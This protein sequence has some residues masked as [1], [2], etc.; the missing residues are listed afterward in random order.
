M[1]TDILVGSFDEKTLKAFLDL[2]GS[3]GFHEL[4][5]RLTDLKVQLSSVYNDNYKKYF[6]VSSGELSLSGDYH[7]VEDAANDFLERFGLSITGN[8][9][10][11]TTN[12][13]IVTF[14]VVEKLSLQE[15]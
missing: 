14:E 5:S 4:H 13:T 12:D 7:T 6:K 15:I 11:E 8:I 3:T 1:I 10:V 9:E 2:H